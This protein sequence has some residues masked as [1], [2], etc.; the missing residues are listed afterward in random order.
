M[1]AAAALHPVS[2]HRPVGGATGNEVARLRLVGDLGGIRETV[3]V[4]QSQ[5]VNMVLPPAIPTD[6]LVS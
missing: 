4:T 6:K 2:S 1:P 5:S 3:A